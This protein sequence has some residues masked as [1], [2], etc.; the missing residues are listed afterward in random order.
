MTHHTHSVEG[1]LPIEK[2]VVSI[3]KSTL[4]NCAIADALLDLLRFVDYF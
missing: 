1:G 4:D 2:D 3:L